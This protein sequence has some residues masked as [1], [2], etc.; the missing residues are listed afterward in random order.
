MTLSSREQQATSDELAQN[1]ELS[2]LAPDEICEDL[3][4]DRGQLDDILD[5]VSARPEDVWMLRDYL[6]A[7][8]LDR[9][10]EPVGYSSLRP[11]MRAAAARWFPL[12]PPIRPSRRS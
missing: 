11:E 5:V 10:R 12:R 6:E 2:A 3:G 4:I 8:V 9:G 7:A 1:F